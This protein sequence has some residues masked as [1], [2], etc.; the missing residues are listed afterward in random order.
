MKIL[1]ISSMDDTCGVSIFTDNKIAA[2]R[3]LGCEIQKCHY[4]QILT[5]DNFD[6]VCIEY[7]SGLLTT[8]HLNSIAAHFQ[9]KKIPV[10]V[11]AHELFGNETFYGD[12][13]IVHHSWPELLSNPDMHYIPHACQEVSTV[14]QEEAREI[15]NLPQDELI[16]CSPGR[17]EQ[18]KLFHENL[19]AIKDYIYIMIG[20]Y[21]PTFYHAHRRYLRQCMKYANHQ[22]IEGTP[23]PGHILNLYSQAADFL[24]FNNSPTYYSIS[25]SATMSLSLGKV[26]FMANVK[27]FDAFNDVNSFK[28]NNINELPA[29]LKSAT[30]DDIFSRELNLMEMREQ[31]KWPVVAHQYLALY[32]Q[33]IEKRK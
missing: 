27:L 3:P 29:I 8:Q 16:F 13:V 28:F 17:L 22:I 25:G 10:I 18:R 23:I 26:A 19:E 32:N 2:L 33:I 7:E 6:L 31:L 20:A 21:P 30:D 24:I 12:A 9:K 15:L 14:S 5:E 11:E 4:S 1:E